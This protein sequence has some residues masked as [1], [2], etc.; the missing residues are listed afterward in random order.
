MNLRLQGIIERYTYGKKTERRV[1]QKRKTK[2]KTTI[3]KRRCNGVLTIKR[4]KY[5]PLVMFK[6]SSLIKTSECNT[7]IG[8]NLLRFYYY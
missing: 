2:R 1:K 8:T 4:L 3:T 5:E 6:E 7:G